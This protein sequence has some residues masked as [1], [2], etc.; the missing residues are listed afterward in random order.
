M[1]QLQ[2]QNCI[3]LF[4]YQKQLKNPENH[5]YAIILNDQ[6]NYKTSNKIDRNNFTHRIQDSYR[7]V[8]MKQN[9]L[10]IEQTN[11]GELEK[12]E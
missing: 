1:F 9:L 11:N 5:F 12:G 8:L 10:P 7:L 3:T 4:N 6:R 2:I